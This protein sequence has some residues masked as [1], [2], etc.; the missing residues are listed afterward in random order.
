MHGQR[1]FSG[2]DGAEGEREAHAAVGQGLPDPLGRLGR[3]TPDL[4]WALD[5]R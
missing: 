2:G 5:K 1:G 3:L 4:G